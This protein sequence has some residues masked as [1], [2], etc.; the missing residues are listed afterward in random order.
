MCFYMTSGPY[1]K[2]DSVCIVLRITQPKNSY[3]YVMMLFNSYII[4][5]YIHYNTYFK[6]VN[7]RSSIP[8][9]DIAIQA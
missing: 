3:T 2:C 5:L 1:K 8:L 7:K 6:C 4:I 9:R